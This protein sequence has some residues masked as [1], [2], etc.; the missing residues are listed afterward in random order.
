ME[1]FFEE[2]G[3]EEERGS[4]VEAVGL[5]LDLRELEGTSAACEGVLFEDGDGEAGFREAGC[6]CEAAYSCAWGLSVLRFSVLCWKGLCLW[7]EV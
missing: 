6:G 2:F 5:V 4:G 7:S 1:C 3:E